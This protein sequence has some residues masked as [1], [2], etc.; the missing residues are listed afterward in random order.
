MFQTA[1]FLLILQHMHITI[2]SKSKPQPRVYIKVTSSVSKEGRR[3]IYCQL[4]AVFDVIQIHR[5]I[6]DCKRSGLCGIM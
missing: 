6:S 5:Q 3:H 1:S 2:G 4:C